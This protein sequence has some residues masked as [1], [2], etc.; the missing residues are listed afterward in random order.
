MT[1]AT[2]TPTVSL[3]L[4]TLS[5]R[6]FAGVAAFFEGIREGKAMADRYDRLSKLSDAELAR[7][8]LGRQEIVR[9]VVNGK[10]I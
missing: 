1:T 8:G 7:L 2:T 5:R 3:S 9:V 4:D 10:K 6:L